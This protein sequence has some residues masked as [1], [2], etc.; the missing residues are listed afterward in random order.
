LLFSANDSVDI[1]T[2]GKALPP[3]NSN[4]AN[5]SLG[6]FPEQTGTLSARVEHFEREAILAEIKR[7][8][9]HITNTAKALGMERSHLYKKCQ[10]LGIDVQ[11]IR[12]V[13]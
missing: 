12:K 11:S 6:S 9:N 7:Q 10:Q 8:Q 1:A 13:D 2:I 5:S 4:S 3:G